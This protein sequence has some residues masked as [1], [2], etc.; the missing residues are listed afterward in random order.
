[1]KFERIIFGIGVLIGLLLIRQTKPMLLKIILI[2]LALSVGLSFLSENININISFFSFGALTLIFTIWSILKSKWTGMIIG[3]FA[4][5]S[6]TW[7]YM[8]FSHWGILQFLM[9]IPLGFYTWTLFNKKDFKNEL[10]VFTALAS[11]ELTEFILCI[12]RMMS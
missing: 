7:S 9:L 12:S 10:G 6:F 3:L 11:F 1:M 8:N 4:F 2:G 5:L